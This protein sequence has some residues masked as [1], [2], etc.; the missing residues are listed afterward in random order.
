MRSS[1]WLKI[2]TG[3]ALVG[4]VAAILSGRSPRWLRIMLVLSIV[5]VTLGTGVYIYRYAS[6]PATVSVAFGSL[7]GD[8]SKVLAAIASRM[9]SANSPVRLK[10]LDK[11]TAREAS[12]AFA[13]GEAD[14]AIVRADTAGLSN[15]RTLLLVSHGVVLI[16]V[17]PGSTIDSMEGLK[18]KTVG[19]LGG[20]SNQRITGLLT[21]EFDLARLNVQFRDLGVADL[22]Q[23]VASKQVHAFLFVIPV[24]EKYL[25]F[26]RNMFP[27]NAKQKMGLVPI[28]SAAA[29]S[30]IS[31]DYESYSLPK[32][33][34]KGAPP[35]PDDDLT[36]LRVP[37]Y[38]VANKKMDDDLAGAIAKAMM[39]ARRDLVSEYPL[40]AYI[41][42]PNTEKD[43]YIPVHPGA[44]AY[45]D[46][47]QKTIFDKYGDQFFYGSMLLGV[48]M[49]ILAG[50][51]NFMTA[52]NVEPP[53]KRPVNRLYALTKRIRE[54]RSEAELA[55]IEHRIDEIV[56]VELEKY[57]EGRSSAGDAAALGLVTHRLEY[58][59]SRCRASLD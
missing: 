21:K 37:F 44:A 1:P 19:V 10:V 51:W 30:A 54:A 53:E 24:S 59:I 13:A 35:I 11:G 43:A 48:L 15:A 8:A 4:G 26:L 49:S 32:G 46:G 47:E 23:A 42:A 56:K 9:A 20:E 6:R 27:G 38:L 45:F 33:T 58:L 25:S 50:T 22:Q 14:L 40:L 36:T 55:D 17:P 7:D 28:E 39:E 52:A 29:I 57:A 12:K 2:V 16:V 3:A 31:R 34:V 41:G 5:V 18:G